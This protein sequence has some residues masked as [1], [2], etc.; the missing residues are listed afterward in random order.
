MYTFRGS[1][2]TIFIF[3]SFLNGGQLLKERICFPRNMEMY[4]HTLIQLHSEWP[5][6]WS[7]GHSECNREALTQLHS[8]QPNSRVLV[9]LS[10]I[11]LKLSVRQIDPKTIEIIPD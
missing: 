2:S 8:E 4:S 3:A 1:N 9:I 7:C 10:A 11:G 5:K 6:L